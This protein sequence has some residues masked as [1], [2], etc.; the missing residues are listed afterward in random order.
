[1]LFKIAFSSD[2]LLYLGVLHKEL[3]I[4]IHPILNCHRMFHDFNVLQFLLG[5]QQEREIRELEVSFR[6]SQ[7][8]YFKSC[9][10]LFF[11]L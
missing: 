2:L 3:L 9:Y 7:K 4:F 10:H 5:L 11:F 6:G 1:M 8:S